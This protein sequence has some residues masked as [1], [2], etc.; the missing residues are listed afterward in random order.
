MCHSVPQ[1]TVGTY[2]S[3]L[4]ARNFDVHTQQ[5]RK[6][7]LLPG[8]AL[9]WGNWWGWAEGAWG[10]KTQIECQTIGINF[11]AVEGGVAVVGYSKS[12]GFGREVSDWGGEGGG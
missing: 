8:G 3:E 7:R 9:I 4:A 12:E 10:C 6:H 2:V 1:C 5:T 11:L